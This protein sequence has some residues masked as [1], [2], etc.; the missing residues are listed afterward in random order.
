MITD[1]EGLLV[2][3]FCFSLNFDFIIKIT[4]NILIFILKSK[5]ENI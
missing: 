2:N 5:L 3:V 4:I 1:Q